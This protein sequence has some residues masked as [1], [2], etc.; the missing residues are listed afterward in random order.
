MGAQE[1][2]REPKGTQENH[3]ESMGTQSNLKEPQKNPNQRFC[4]EAC[5]P[6]YPLK[7][8]LEL[9]WIRQQLKKFMEKFWKKT[10]FQIFFTR[11][12][13]LFQDKLE[14]KIKC[15]CKKSNFPSKNFEIKSFRHTTCYLGSWL[16][17]QNGLLK[18]LPINSE[19]SRSRL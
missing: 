18:K 10:I 7:S 4:Q 1:N 13:L 17:K 14:E 9:P 15:W 16:Q 5:I 3:R 8:F 19:A 6:L 2:P 11:K 12:W